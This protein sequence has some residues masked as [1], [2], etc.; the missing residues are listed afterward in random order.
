MEKAREQSRGNTHTIA[1]AGY[2]MALSDEPGRARGV[3][4]EL[5]KLSRE[6]YVPPY[7]LAMVHYGLGE[8]EEALAWLEKAFEEC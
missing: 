2:V 6:R 3:L 7:N 8:R 5:R 1:L 4:E